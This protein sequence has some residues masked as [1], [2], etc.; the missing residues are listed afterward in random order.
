MQAEADRG[1]RSPSWRTVFE[2]VATT[3][4]V[5]SAVV[6]SWVAI[7]NRAAARGYP[8][9]QADAPLPTQPVSLEGALRK[10]DPAAKVALIMFSDFQCPFCG[11]FAG[12]TLP[13]IDRNYVSRGK[14]LLAFRNFPLSSHAYA[15]KAAEAGECAARQG[16]FWPM[17]DR[18][19]RDPTKLDQESLLASARALGLDV[20][21][22]TTCLSGDTVANVKADVAAGSS[23][24]VVSTPAFLVGLV[25]ADGA[26]RIT[27]RIRGARPYGDFAKVLDKQL[28]STPR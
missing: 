13:Q 23:V 22:F 25:Q 4:M 1:S 24:G 14:V 10:G 9:T 12:N 11:Q 15:Q 21:P 2:V 20:A 7:G 8:P 27:D 18:L 26:V 5:C 6:V 3:V 28:G 16:Q 17:H 19:F